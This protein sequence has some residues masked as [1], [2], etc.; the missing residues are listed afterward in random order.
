MA[1]ARRASEQRLANALRYPRGRYGAA[2]ASQLA[3]IPERTL[4]DWAH[5]SVLVPDYTN[6]RPKQWSY[7]D[8]VLARM[9]Y[10]LRHKGMDRTEAARHVEQTRAL[11]AEGD[12]RAVT[13]RS[14]G[15]ELHRSDETVA[16]SGQIAFADVLALLD[17]FHVGEVAALVREV[18]RPDLWGPDLVEPSRR[19]RISPWVMA[20]EPCVRD[21]RLPTSTLYALHHVRQ[22]KPAAIVELY[23]GINEMDVEDAIAL[24]DAVAGALA[25]QRHP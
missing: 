22:L 5:E 15:R 10:W 19:T 3:G 24:V 1:R 16:E 8:L 17:E 11:L 4:Y 18:G 21:T 25:H 7:R 14:D 13:A 23:L 9:L 12:P 20:G 6:G 2:R